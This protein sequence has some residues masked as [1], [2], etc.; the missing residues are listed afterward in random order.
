MNLTIIEAI[1]DSKVFGSVIKDQRTF[2]NWKICLK[3][4]FGLSMNKKEL[5]IYRKFT[6]RKKP[7]LKSFEEVFLIVGRR[8]GKSTIAALIA[9]FLAVFKD[10]R[11]HLDFG[12]IGYIMAIASDRRQASVVFNKIR[13]I[14]SLPL[15]RG[16]VVNE[17]KEEI[18]LNNQI[19][20]SVV[21]CSY[22]ALRGFT[23]LAAICDEMAFWRHE[24]ANPSE[25][26]LTAL[27]PGMIIKGSLLAAI[28]T[29]YAKVGSLYEAFRSKYGTQDRFS[30]IWKAASRDMNPTI[31]KRTIDKALKADPSAARAEWLAE[32]RED[33][34]TF[35][36][37]E[38]IESCIIPRRFGLPFLE[39]IRYYA[40][41]D[42][43]GG[44]VD[45]FTLGIAHKEK[46]TKKIILDILLEKLSPF[47]PQS[48]V[49]EYSKTLKN[50]GLRKVTG[51]R[52]AGEWVVKQFENYGIKYE[53]SKLNKSEIYLEFEPLM[54]QGGIELLDNR[55]LFAQLRGLERRTRS[56]GKDSIDHV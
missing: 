30:L 26:I 19:T 52:Y 17:S 39:G 56:G 44:R 54:T 48:V 37:T 55:R 6:G 28:S 13:A 38:I 21:T 1:E 50:Y 47:K 8:G 33:L 35:L 11:E 41:A 15:F 51:D 46:T 36:T 10:W 40:F 31:P 14:L 27:R 9:V 16:M 32:F 42:P 7:P 43:S 22:R 25:E 23:V 2:K 24:G 3:A 4:I 18:E 53:S 45:S 49:E 20:I 29:P 5:E 34:E 12:E